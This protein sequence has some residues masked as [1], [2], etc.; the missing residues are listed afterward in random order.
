MR[1]A[2]FI[3]AFL[4]LVSCNN[5]MDA[6]LTERQ[7]FIR[8]FS[9]KLALTAADMKVTA[10]GDIVILGNMVHPRFANT[11]RDLVTVL[12]RVDKNGNRIGNV[13]YL[14]GGKGNSI[15]ELPNNDFLVVGESNPDPLTGITSSRIL[16]VNA[17]LV[18]TDSIGKVHASTSYRGLTA[19][20][21]ESGNAV[22]LGSYIA[23]DQIER[24]YLEQLNASLQSQWYQEFDLLNRNYRNSR[25]VQ[26]NNGNIV[27]ASAIAQEGTT[28]L[29][30]VSI[31]FVPEGS[32]F[33]NYSSL[34]ETTQ[35]YFRAE[36]IQPAFNR[37]FGYGVIGTRANT[38]GTQANV[39]FLRVDANGNIDPTSI[40]YYDAILSQTNPSLTEGQTQTED[41]GTAIA[42]TR[43]GGF[44]LAGSY[45]VTSINSDILLIKTDLLGNIM[46]IKTFGGAGSESVVRVR[47]TDDGGLLICGTNVVQGVA[48]VFLIKTDSNGELKN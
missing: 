31:P 5:L 18:K 19:A 7:T 29:S 21:D 23:A 3:S 11:T 1:S 40:R 32:V 10:N 26:V 12:I 42:S 24:P 37:A 16:R 28:N 17:S 4:I 46:W 48:S 38:T 22:V 39:F 36:D 34:G 45:Q 27:W 44:V 15:L 6:E 13:T 47:E 35:Q 20:L 33:T 9:G 41:A 43:D 8:L 30:Y 2:P 25:S 14:P